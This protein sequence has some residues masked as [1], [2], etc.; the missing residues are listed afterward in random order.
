MLRC[1]QAQPRACALRT[2]WRGQPPPPPTAAGLRQGTKARL[3]RAASPRRRLLA[4]PSRRQWGGSVRGAGLGRG[5]GSSDGRG[6]AAPSGKQRRPRPLGR[7]V[8]EGERWRRRRR[9][10]G[11]AW[12][13][14]QGGGSGQCLTQVA[15]TGGRAGGRASGE[16]EAAALLLLLSRALRAGRGSRENM[17]EAEPSRPLPSVGR[18][19][20]RETLGAAAAS[21]PLAAASP[22]EVSAAGE[23]WSL[24][25]RAAVGKEA[26]AAGGRGRGG[27]AGSARS[28]EE[29]SRRP[30]G[31][32]PA[33]PASVGSRSR[34]LPGWIEAAPC[35]HPPPQ[36]EAGRLLSGL[37]QAS[38]AS[39]SPA[40]GCRQDGQTSVG[41]DPA[42]LFRPRKRRV[43]R[44]DVGLLAGRSFVLGSSRLDS[45]SHSAAFT[46]ERGTAHPGTGGSAS[47][48]GWRVKTV[49]PP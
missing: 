23:S 8:G 41:G 37:P 14:C 48:P 12:R 40:T 20:A 44:A 47:I 46:G 42:L 10:R 29:S 18:R 43:S 15:R 5:G 32:A 24:Q 19:R 36:R 31:R 16:G 21:P 30:A 28:G 6:T 7:R 3:G 25:P 38:S 13:S 22:G 26:A 1:R 45:A 4:S 27:N 9:R 33:A 2:E 39:L 34:A 49:C 35:A 11:R 17:A